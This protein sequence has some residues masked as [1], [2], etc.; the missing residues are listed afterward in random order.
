MEEAFLAFA[1][2]I[3]AR[4]SL[5]DSVMWNVMREL[6]RQPVIDRRLEPTADLPL[7]ASVN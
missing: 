1:E 4:P 3:G 7:F 6:A 2:V 5:L